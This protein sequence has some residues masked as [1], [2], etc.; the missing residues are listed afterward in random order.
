MVHAWS[1]EDAACI[2]R[3]RALKLQFV[4]AFLPNGFLLCEIHVSYGHREC[5]QK[6]G[7]WWS[8]LNRCR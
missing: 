8:S 1:I 7:Q 3:A 4:E 2:L 6:N 5:G